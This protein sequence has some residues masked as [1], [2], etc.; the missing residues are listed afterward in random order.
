MERAI[1]GGYDDV[2]RLIFADYEYKSHFDLRTKMYTL[3]E[4]FEKYL[5]YLFRS[6]S[7]TIETNSNTM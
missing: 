3:Q 5:M 2:M 7:V 1:L 6:S 4:D